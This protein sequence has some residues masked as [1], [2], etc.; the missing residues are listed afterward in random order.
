MQTLSHGV[1]KPETGDKGSVWFPAMEDNCDILNDHNHDGSN[2]A[3]I[4]STSISP[5]TQ[6]VS[7]ASWAAVS[8]GTYRQLLTVP[9]GKTYDNSIILFRH[10]VSKKQMYLEVEPVSSNTYYVYINDNTV[11]LTAFYV[12]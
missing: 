7:S 4:P 6:S 1:K 2:S 12:S 3:P 9:N 11:S 8:G 10:S 5:V